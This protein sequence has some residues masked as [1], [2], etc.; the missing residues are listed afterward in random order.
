MGR[1]KKIN[2]YPFPYRTE[3]ELEIS[4]LTNLGLGLGRVTLASS[5]QRSAVSDQPDQP[6]PAAAEIENPESKIENRSGWVVMV[7]FTLPGE[8]VRARVYRNNKNFSEADLVE[9]LTPS[10]HRVAAPCPLFGRCGG[11]QYQH[12]AYAEQ[13]A[14]K[15]RQVEELLEHMA[16]IAFP[17]SPVIGSPR[18]YG[19]RSKI[20]PHFHVGRP[21]DPRTPPPAETPIGFLKQGT[22]FDLV[23][24]PACPI[25]TPEINAKLPEV[26]ARTRQRLAAGEFKRDATLLLRHAQEGVITD[27][28]AVIHE[29]IAE[30]NCNLLGYTF[31]KADSA[32]TGT[33]SAAGEADTGGRT[34]RL[35][36]L[37][38]DFFQNNPF[39]LPA[40]TGYVRD[41]AKASGARFLVD[42]YCGSGL[43]A[44]S[45]AP[46]FE[47]VAGVEVSET[48][49]Q[50]AREN[51]AAN[52]IANAVFSAGDAATI[53]AGLDAAFAP[54]ETAVVI[55]PP[56]KGCDESFLA[57]LFTFGPRAV[58]YVSCDPAT[59]MRDLRSFL[60]AGYEL[61]AVQPFDLFPQTR[62]L[63]CVI[64]L[65]RA[66]GGQVSHR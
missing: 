13:L 3:I 56:R 38:R 20:T 43:F 53:F 19:Y 18:E 29:V 58:V 47:R 51:A 41:Q 11:C 10:P 16:G 62:H 50:F 17:V 40:F 23:D 9:V 35:H 48:S 32:A 66:S 45:C 22:R 28:D 61:T 6:T 55:D 49:V 5:G 57:Q 39:I 1:K 42:A 65:R 36:F 2:D 54:T 4:T 27:Y 24:V 37:A 21:D 26:R 44:L 7:P 52:G 14:W 60:A 33:T 30:A 12:L 31:A 8:R 59:Q 15:R 64:S 25:A 34:F 63:E 46:A